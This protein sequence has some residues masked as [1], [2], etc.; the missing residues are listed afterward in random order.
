MNFLVAGYLASKAFLKTQT[1][2]IADPAG[3]R[4]LR[5]LVKRHKDDGKPV[6]LPARSIAA[7]RED[8]LQ[9]LYEPSVYLSSVLDEIE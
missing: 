3:E 8:V 9:P 6:S 1:T 7:Q 5:R 2:T 4:R